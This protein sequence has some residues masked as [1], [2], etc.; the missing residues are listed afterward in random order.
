[1]SSDC[2][3]T[4][5]AVKAILKPGPRVVTSDLNKTI[6]PKQ[7]K[8]LFIMKNSAYNNELRNKAYYENKLIISN[9]TI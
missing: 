6:R 7:S 9:W 3:S 1:M 8:H 2:V 4:N 5:E